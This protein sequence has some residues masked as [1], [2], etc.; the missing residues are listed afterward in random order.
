MTDPSSPH[1]T[2]ALAARADLPQILAMVRALIREL[3]SRKMSSLLAVR[4]DASDLAQ[5]VVLEL[6][7]NGGVL[8]FRG[9]ESTK[10]LA[11]EILTRLLSDKIRALRTGK[12]DR[13]R[14]SVLPDDDDSR[15]LQPQPTAPAGD[16]AL[17]AE[18]RER[19]QRGEQL[20]GMLSAREQDVIRRRLAGQGHR[21][22]AAAM[23]ISVALSQRLLSD[24]RKR[25]R[26]E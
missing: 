14:E 8:Q 6:M 15:A 26:A 4:E 1:L 5:S 19:L 10:A 9:P 24:A 3:A 25:L 11:R 21:E 18:A 16:P 12:R 7:Q 2:D 13:R 20:L 22:I 23:G 17:L